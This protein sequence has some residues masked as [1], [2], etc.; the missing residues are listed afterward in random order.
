M[1]SSLSCYEINPLHKYISSV[2]KS[3]L[4]RLSTSMNTFWELPCWMG[5]FWWKWDETQYRPH[6]HDEP[7][8][9]KGFT[10]QGKPA[11]KVL[12]RW[13]EKLNS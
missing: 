2:L 12:V 13:F 5:L 7:G 11:E 1:K 9:D 6:Y 8:V 4:Y 3:M 10:I